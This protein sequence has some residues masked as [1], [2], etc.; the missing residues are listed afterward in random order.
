M[1]Q[2]TTKNTEAPVAAKKPDNHRS[3]WWCETCRDG[4]DM[5]PEQMTDHLLTIHGIN[6]CRTPY[7][8]QKFPTHVDKGNVVETYEMVV[9][10]KIVLTNEQVWIG[11]KRKFKTL[12]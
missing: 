6:I 3:T 4:A 9:N 1:S 5:T 2:S 12:L 11:A 8:R 7:T 10:G